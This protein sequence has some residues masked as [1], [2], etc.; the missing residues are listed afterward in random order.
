LKVIQTLPELRTERVGWSD[1]GLVPTM[2]YLHDGHLSLIRAARAECRTVVMSLFV[3]PAQFGPGEDFARYPRD[4]ERDLR[5]AELAGVDAVFM[6]Q[7]A[8]V[9]PPDFDT[10]VEV[11]ALTHLWEGQHRPGHFRGVATVVLK[12]FQMVQPRRAYFG[13]KDYQQL[14]DVKKMVADLN[15]PVEVAACPTIREASG[16]A[17][18]S[19]NSYLDEDRRARAAVLYRAL[20]RA[21]ELASDGVTE[22]SRLRAA[23]DEILA[24]EPDASLEYLAVVD[25]ATLEPL[26]RLSAEGRIVAA[27]YFDGVR[28]I[29]NLALRP[30]LRGRY[31]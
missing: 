7:L 5:L 15:M 20:K 2:G 21:Q 9:Y 6:P 16:L 30:V 23:M 26:Q 14:L 12:L 29:D 8:E 3:N 25:P 19:R 18:S 1:V 27:M 10:W 11:H 24:E 13:E 22:V 28:L 4:T 31:G 17:L